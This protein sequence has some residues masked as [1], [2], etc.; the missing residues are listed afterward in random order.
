MKH[1]KH[2]VLRLAGTY[3]AIIMVM[4]LAFSA[5]FYNASVRELNR[6]HKEAVG[7]EELVFQELMAERATTAKAALLVDLMLV[8]V[9]ALIVGSM[10]SYLLAQA[11]LK[12]IED[13]ME[14]QSQF[15]SD[16]SHE[17]RTPLTALRA[18]NEVALRDKKLTLRDAKQ[19][20]ADNVD[21]IARLQDLTNSMLGLLR[22]DSVVQTKEVADLA[23]II[24]DAVTMVVSQA[25]AK[26]IAIVPAL[27]DV[28]LLVNRQQLVQLITILLDNAVK[29]SPHGKT[30]YISTAAKGR[31]AIITVRDEGIGMDDVALKQIFTRFYRAEQSRTTV[32]YGLGLAIAKKITL[33]HKGTI[34]ATSQVGVGST[35]TV[36]IP[37]S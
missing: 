7:A 16:A 11:T 31:M 29:Y 2:D 28:K 34:G 30:I 36:K 23:S 22:D 32:G 3:L 24:G 19:V 6:P 21:D 37:R 18:A 4:S 14:A 5:I 20:I 8:N 35:F 26:D 15:V 17:L 13:N 10:L 25:M 9:L 33:A 27:A 1:L 12:P